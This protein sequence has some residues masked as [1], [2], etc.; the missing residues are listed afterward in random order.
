MRI[1]CQGPGT[2]LA[3]SIS[4]SAIWTEK[5]VLASRCISSDVIERVTRSVN[6]NPW[7]AAT[8]LTMPRSRSNARRCES[9]VD[10]C[11]H[12]ASMS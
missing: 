3:S 1:G 12:H 7:S 10:S 11:A 9:L 4:R 2:G 5:I 6:V 8:L